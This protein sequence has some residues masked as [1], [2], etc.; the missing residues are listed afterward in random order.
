MYVEIV[1]Y[2]YVFIL[3]GFRVLIDMEGFCFNYRGSFFF[4]C[5]YLRKIKFIFISLN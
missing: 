3:N 5:I 1:F 2:C 4:E